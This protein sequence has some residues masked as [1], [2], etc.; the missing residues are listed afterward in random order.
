MSSFVEKKGSSTKPY[1]IDAF[2]KKCSKLSLP[3]REKLYIWFTVASAEHFDVNRS[4]LLLSTLNSF[5]YKR[6]SART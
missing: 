6:N 1:D 3:Q 5:F 2:M 4:K